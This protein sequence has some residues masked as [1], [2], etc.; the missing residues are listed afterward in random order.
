MNPRE[1]KHT[2]KFR[3]RLIKT[4]PSRADAMAL[5]RQLEAIGA[6]L[7]VTPVFEGGAPA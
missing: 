6:R 5:A 7:E 3:P 2:I 1:A 4:V